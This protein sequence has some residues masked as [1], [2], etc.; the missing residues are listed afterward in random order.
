ML[1]AIKDLAYIRR[2][3][4]FRKQNVNSAFEDYYKIIRTVRFCLSD[5]N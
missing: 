1:Y 2:K 5:K 3:K 4:L